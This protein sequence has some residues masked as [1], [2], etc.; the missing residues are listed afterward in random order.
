V[1]A[2]AL[3]TEVNA[4]HRTGYTPGGAT[5]TDFFDPAGTT[6][7]TLALTAPIAASA[8]NIAAGATNAPGDGS[9]ALQIA[10]LAGTGVLSLAGKSL[11]EFYVEIA[12]GVGLEV[13]NA[14]EDADTQQELV[15]YADLRR[16]SVSGVS[17]EEEMVALIAQQQAYSAAARLV[18]VADEMMQDLMNTI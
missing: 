16:S 7:G 3:V 6:A 8:T 18:R 11:R 5:N 15:D 14:M 17:V 2:G 12:A 1:F 10:G 4:I 13:R 9:I